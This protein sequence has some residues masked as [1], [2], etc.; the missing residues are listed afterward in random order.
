[1][2]TRGGEAVVHVADNGAGLDPAEAA[3][4]FERFYQSSPAAPGLGLGLNIV[5]LIV[6]RFGGR[7]S[8]ES[9][10]RGRGAVATVTLPLCLAGG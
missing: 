2:E 7:V 3:Q 8:M 4:V 1:M 9:Q 10:G 5:R 6:E